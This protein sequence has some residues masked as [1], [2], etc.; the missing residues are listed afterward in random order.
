M[1]LDPARER[2][3]ALVLDGAVGQP[4][5][6]QCTMILA[7]TRVPLRPYGWLFAAELGGGWLRALGSHV[8]DFARS[9]FGEI[10]D[11][12]AMLHTAIPERPD[13]DGNLHRCTADDGFTAMLRSQSGVTTVIHTTSAAP[14]NLTPTMLVVGHEGVLEVIGDQ[15]IIR[16]T[17]AGQEEMWALEPGSGN[18]LLLS[19]RRWAG[20]VCDAV[21]RG[22][23]DAGSPTFADGLEC[24][25][26]MDRLAHG[27]VDRAPTRSS[28]P[29]G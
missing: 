28:R 24:V 1:R 4:Q 20:V 12:S 14:V 9:A 15:R 3:R 25:E 2:L 11:G 29:R 26:M 21:R 19:M 5:H 7:T 27:R 6:F 17:G 16:H 8:I 23:A 10:V 13:A 22:A 18:P